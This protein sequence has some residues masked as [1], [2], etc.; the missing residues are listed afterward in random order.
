MAVPP[1]SRAAL[2]GLSVGGPG[3]SIDDAPDQRARREYRARLDDLHAGLDQA[4][5][6]ADIG[7]AEQLRAELD[8]LMVQLAGRL[9][10]RP[11]LRSPAETA[12][13]AV[14]KVLRT[15]IGKLLDVHP[16][17]GR[18]LRDTVQMGTL[19][20]YAPPSPVQWDVRF[21]PAG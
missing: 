10:S 21:A 7:R 1:A 11:S 16:V 9:G 5:Q 8:Q 20:V 14:T 12:R 13:K 6:F 4:E 2:H 3:A 19:C 17:L 18:H 15:Q